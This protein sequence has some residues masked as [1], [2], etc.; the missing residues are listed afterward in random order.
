MGEKGMGRVL[1]VEDE[2]TIAKTVRLGLE[3]EGFKVTLAEDGLE[4][5]KQVRKD[6]PD[7]V[8][9][10]IMLPKFDGFKVCRLIKFARNTGH[11]PV[12]LCSA[13]NSEADRE[14]G[15]KAGADDYILKPFNLVEL[16]ENVRSRIT[17]VTVASS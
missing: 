9:L 15:R 16:I 13:R 10:D 14:K 7:L 2:L 12:I 4:A 5:L 8:L 11:I 1:V 17:P 3:A 6:P